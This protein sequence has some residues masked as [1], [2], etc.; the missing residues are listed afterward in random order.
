M[1]KKKTKTKAKKEKIEGEV[2]DKI[3]GNDLGS[4]LFSG[5]H[6]VDKEFITIPV[7]PKLDFS[8][9]GGIPEGSFC[10]FNG[11]FK[12]GKTLSA[13]H[14]CA[15]AQSIQSEYGPRKIFIANVEGRLKPRDLKGIHHLN[16]DDVTIIGSAPGKILY[17]NDYL[18]IVE[19]VVNEVPGSIIVFDSLSALCSKSRADADIGDRFRDDVPLMLSSFCKRISNVLP[20]NN[21]IFIGITHLIANQGQGHKKWLES[22]GQK[23]QYQADVKLRISHFTPWKSGDTQIGQIVHWECGTSALG[24]PGIK[25]DSNIRYGW[26]IDEEAELIDLCI[27]TNLIKKKRAGWLE[28]PNGEN[29][30]GLDIAA[31]TLRNNKELYDELYREFKSLIKSS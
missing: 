17:A 24:P 26:G 9:G 5:S 15:N 31:Q 28:F 12:A 11:P 20:I 13:I 10:V 4:I 29:A 7:S 25:V 1:A 2:E 14:F 6:L 8:L 21:N 3:F 27:D 18:S 23:I 19:R 22:A 30:Q 16:I